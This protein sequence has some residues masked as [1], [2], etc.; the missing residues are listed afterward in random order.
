MTVQP[1]PDQVG[2][3]SGLDDDGLGPGIAHPDEALAAVAATRRLIA[4]LRIADPP[5][6][7]LER[8]TAL[9]DEAAALLD[10]HAVEGVYMQGAL[11][12]RADDP[13]PDRFEV[14]TR[15]LDDPGRFFPY[16]PIIGEWNPIAPPAVLSWDGE[17]I[18]GTATVGATHAGPPNMVHGGVIALLFDE[19]LGCANMCAG[20]GGFTGTLT[21]RYERPTPLGGELELE[22]HIETVEGR[23]ITTR[24]TITH[25]GQ[26][27]AR[28]EGVFIRVSM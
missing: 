8:V 22:S 4:A 28:A 1:A 18:H 7:V 21:V 11:R 13:G 26:V 19:V 24:G 14:G 12:P 25:A 5:A 27:T 15:S 16:S 6:D 9:V 20:V 17:R 2:S 3:S 10:P 23:K